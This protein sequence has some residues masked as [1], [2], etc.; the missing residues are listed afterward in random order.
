MDH[1][2]QRQLADLRRQSDAFLRDKGPHN[3]RSLAGH[4]TKELNK[5][6]RRR[7]TN[8]GLAELAKH[9]RKVA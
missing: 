9:W 2:Q 3:I 1:D 7:I 5:R 8:R 4:T 6:R